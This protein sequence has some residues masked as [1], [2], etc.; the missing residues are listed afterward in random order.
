MTDESAGPPARTTGRVLLIRH[1]QT[2]WSLTDRHTGRTDI[3]LTAHGESDAHALTGIADRLGLTDPYVFASPRTRARRTAEL[4]GLTVDAVD[5]CFAEWDYGDYEGLTRAEIHARHDPDWAIWTSGA[6]G[7][8][9]VDE[10]T[11]R[12]D[13][14]VDMVDGR[15][16]GTDV[17]VVSHGHF[18]RSFICRFLGWSIAHGA[19]I[20]LRPAGA[21]L[22]IH[23]ASGRRLSTLVGPEGAAA[24]HAAL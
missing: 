13:R 24:T 8:E 15:L 21:A 2:E 16:A 3:G 1:G 22:L 14:A 9:S 17:I 5:D 12:V 19:E 4:A 11:E 23:L 20:D 7:G 10:M 6:P 18:S